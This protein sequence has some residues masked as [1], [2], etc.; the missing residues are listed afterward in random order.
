[1]AKRYLTDD[2]FNM[3]T[4]GGRIPTLTAFGHMSPKQARMV[5]GRYR[6]AIFHFEPECVTMET[7]IA[8]T[9]I[10]AFNPTRAG[11]SDHYAHINDFCERH[12]HIN[13][14]GLFNLMPVAPFVGT[15][16]DDLRF[17]VRFAY[18]IVTKWYGL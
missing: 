15:L 17:K 11:L 14:A 1:M 4:T 16:P 7:V 5:A 10:G 2:E 3:I 12:P 13:P 6:L 8:A 9:R 18:P